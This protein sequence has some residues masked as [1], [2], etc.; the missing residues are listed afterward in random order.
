VG[1]AASPRAHQLRP[2]DAVAVPDLPVSDVSGT[3]LVTERGTEFSGKQLRT[4]LT[5]AD[6]NTI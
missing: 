4:T 3:F 1:T 5:F 2:G 6:V